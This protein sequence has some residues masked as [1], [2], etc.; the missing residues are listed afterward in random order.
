[1]PESGSTLTPRPHMVPVMSPTQRTPLSTSPTKIWTQINR[2]GEY[3]AAAPEPLIHLPDFLVIN[4]G[5]DEN[6]VSDDEPVKVREDPQQWEARK[7]QN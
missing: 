3:R 4:W 5:V 7:L 6:F 1:M 2:R